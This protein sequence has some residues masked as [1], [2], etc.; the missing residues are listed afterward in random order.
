MPQLSFPGRRPKPSPDPRLQ[1]PTPLAVTREQALMIT[2]TLY[3]MASLRRGDHPL[4]YDEDK[5]DALAALHDLV[6]GQI[7]D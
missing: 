3:D 6:D 5:A 2:E 4:W 7:P 1:D